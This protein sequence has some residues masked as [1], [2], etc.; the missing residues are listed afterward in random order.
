MSVDTRSV[1]QLVELLTTRTLDDTVHWEAADAS[2]AEVYSTSFAHGSVLLQD[3][4]FGS[5]S[6]RILD[7]GGKEIFAENVAGAFEGGD[8]VVKQGIQRLFD[9]VRA[10]DSRRQHVI[11]ALLDELAT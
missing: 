9:I 1:R 2:A 6:M 3:L 4:P 10:T 5:V 11:D 7:E 8:A